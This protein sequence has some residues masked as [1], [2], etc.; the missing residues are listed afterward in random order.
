MGKT[1]HHKN[2]RK[3][4]CGYDYGAKYDCDRGYCQPKGPE[5][6]NL[7]DRERRNK[8]KKLIQ[9]ELEEYDNDVE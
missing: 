8:S 3:N 6:K 2:Q 5:G 9:Q 4:K 1:Y 7:A